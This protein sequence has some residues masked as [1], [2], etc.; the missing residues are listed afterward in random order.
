VV[1][2]SI[3]LWAWAIL[4]ASAGV[5][6]CLFDPYGHLTAADEEEFQRVCDSHWLKETEA[7]QWA[8]ADS[9]CIK[10]CVRGVRPRFGG[11]FLANQ[12]SRF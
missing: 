2:N 9:F 8:F 10:S 1:V 5:L 7:K 3:L 6:A 12:R 11:M 4:L